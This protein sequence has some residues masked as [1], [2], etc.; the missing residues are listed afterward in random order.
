M[1]ERVRRSANVTA[2]LNPTLIRAQSCAW[3]AHRSFTR[4]DSGV[5][6]WYFISAFPLRTEFRHFFISAIYLREITASTSFAGVG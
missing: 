4:F 1:A 6:I 2:T 5:F 3:L